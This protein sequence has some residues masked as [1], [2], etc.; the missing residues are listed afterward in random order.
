MHRGYATLPEGQVHYHEHGVGVPLLLLH[1]SPR[2]AW[3]FA[4]LMQ[5]MGARFRCLAP[6]TPGF[7]MSD[8]PPAGARM[9]DLAQ[10]MVRFLDAQGIE[11]AHVLGF[12]TGNKIGAAMAAHWPSRVDRLVLVGMTH[13]MVVSRKARNAAIMNIVRKYMNVP[14][15]SPDGSHLLPQ[16]ASDFRDVSNAWWNP[17]VMTGG[18]ITEAVL[19]GQADRAI[20]MIQ[21]RDAIRQVYQMNFDFDFGGTLRRVRAPTQVIE[22]CMPDEAHLG[23]QGPLMLKLLKNGELLTLQNAGFDATTAFAR[24]IAQAAGRFLRAR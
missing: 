24:E 13:S 23:A 16:W 9:E 6:D 14:A 4:P 18:A 22:C 19:R 1:E 5:R 12:H 11:R 21:C 20:E 17:A 2:A 8:P 3:S 7:G 15:G 10:T